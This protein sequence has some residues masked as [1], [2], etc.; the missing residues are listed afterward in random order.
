[1]KIR[2][3]LLS[4]VGVA[5]YIVLANFN[6]KMIKETAVSKDHGQVSAPQAH[7]AKVARRRLLRK[8]QLPY[9]WSRPHL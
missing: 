8:R 1:M 6:S 2:L 4:L 3:I 9:Q 5:A 7:P